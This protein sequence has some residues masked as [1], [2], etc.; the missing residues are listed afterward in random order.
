MKSFA[1]FIY[2]F[3]SCKFGAFLYGLYINTFTPTLLLD[4][5]LGLPFYSVLRKIPGDPFIT[6][7]PFIEFVEKV[8]PTRLLEP[9]LLLER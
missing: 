5:N 6:A 3:K 9:T 4:T 7:Y 1:S 8:Q 2:F